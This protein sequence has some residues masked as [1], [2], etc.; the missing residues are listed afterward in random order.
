[1]T[2]PPYIVPAAGS[3]R[4]NA[5][6]QFIIGVSPIGTIAPFDY[7]ATVI[8]QY[9]NSPILT[10]LIANFFQYVDQ[11][12]NLDEFFDLVWNVDT[13]VG[14]GLDV[15]GRIVGVSRVIP[16]EVENV[17]LGFQESGDAYPFGQA[18][19]YAGVSLTGNFE[20]VDQA[21]RVLI[22]AKA[23]ANVSDGSISSIN[24]L[25]LSLFPNRGNCYVADNNDMTMD[26]VF[27][28]ALSAAE[29]AIVQ[30]TNVLPKPVGVDVSVLVL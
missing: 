28:F 7:A 4:S 24:H 29:L 10:T 2:G 26:Y 20:L 13:A 5:I 6:G 3:I 11:T 30:Q 22:F 25:L 21:F 9:A 14:Y 23:F 12:R 15:W 16:V 17:Y 1:M 8:S 27:D 18:S 19:L